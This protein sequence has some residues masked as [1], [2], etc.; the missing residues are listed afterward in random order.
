MVTM[1]LCEARGP[2][3]WDPWGFVVYKSPEIRDDAAWNRLQAATLDESVAPY[4]G[5]PGMNELV[6]RMQTEWIEEGL[7]DDADPRCAFIAR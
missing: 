3:K 2:T 4:R 1:R 7:G 6:E 5:Y